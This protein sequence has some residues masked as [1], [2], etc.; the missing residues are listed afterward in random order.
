[1]ALL[2]CWLVLTGVT[3][4]QQLAR[5]FFDNRVLHEIRID[6]DPDDWATLRQNY[7][8]DTYYRA[9]VSSGA[10]TASAVGIRSR[11]RG[12]R[13][14]EKPNIDVNVQKYA[15]NQTFAG[16]GFF[17][18]KANNQDPSMLH[19]A[20]AFELYRKMGLHAAREAPAKLYINGEYFGL[21][22]IVEHQDEDFLS[23]NLG[24]DTG[25]LFE[26]TPNAFYHFEDLGDDPAVYAN[27]L[28]AKSD[29]PNYQKFIDLVKAVNYSSSSD[30]VNAV[31]RYL[32]LKLYLTLVATENVIAEV[33]G[34]WGSVY[35]T[36]NIYLY[37]FQGQDLFDW[38]PWDKDL[39]FWDP[40]RLLPDGQENVLARRLMAIPQYRTF[41]LSQ[42]AKAAT[43]MGGAGG[44]A[45][46][47]VSRMYN[48]IR[49]AA[50]DD[51]H[52]QCS[53]LGVARPPSPC[54]A[55]D[56]E[57]AIQAMH[58]FVATRAAFVQKAVAQQGYQA[59][60]GGPA[61]GAVALLSPE[62]GNE[63]TA[64][65]I[66]TVRGV[67]LDPGTLTGGYILPRT[68]GRSFVAVEGVRAP[69]VAI[70]GSEIQVQIPWDLPPG[71]AA[72][73]LAAE[74][75]LSNT[76]DTPVADAA[77]A[78][79]AVVRADG[80]PVSAG[81]PAAAGEMVT[82]YAAGVGSVDTYIA[83]GDRAPAG[84]LIR[85]TEIPVVSIGADQARVVFAGLSP[86]FVGLYQINAILPV[87]LS[88]G[89]SVMLSVASDGKTVSSQMVI[90]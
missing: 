29:N 87:N 16:L 42:L 51:P 32:D 12:S 38:I 9:N 63:V 6:V 25:D 71:T 19:E 31:S 15:K 8:E 7:L 53:Q 47:E 90:H 83:T 61:I 81:S 85:T 74:G 14:P 34:L 70:S 11:G 48:L 89:Q 33:D 82:L 5:D 46:Q 72:V 73:A 54:G 59:P 36:N 27:L 20:V 26:W 2:A 67:T 10:M 39:A 4:G 86:G 65:S 21:Y 45:D 44:W 52:K 35:G 68:A 28:E 40:Q 1:L 76:I 55:A 17:I 30:F 41:Y 43:L 88:S 80:A 66:A 78:I 22:T 75:E 60:T 77:P 69:L 79:L 56:F 57:Q 3:S 23:R 18:L 58:A 24:E 50:I 13:S 37:R 84:R 62:G 64:G 49:P